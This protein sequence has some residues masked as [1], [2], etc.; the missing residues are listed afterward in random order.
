LLGGYVPTEPVPTTPSSDK[1]TLRKGDEG[2]WVRT[3][4]ILLNQNNTDP[5]LEPDGKFGPLTDRAVR[6]YQR[7]NGLTVDSI[8]G[9]LTWGKLLEDVPDDEPILLFTATIPIIT[10]SVAALVKV[11]D[12]TA[13]Q[14]DEVVAKYPGTTV[15]QQN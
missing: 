13:W 5:P 2:E 15:T 10:D 6:E 8:V 7:G 4:Q 14:A 12:L 3:L 11:S 1:P 9:K